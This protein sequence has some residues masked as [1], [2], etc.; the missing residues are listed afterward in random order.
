MPTDSPPGA[1]RLWEF[2]RVR[3]GPDNRRYAVANICEFT[4]RVYGPVWELD[5]FFTAVEQSAPVAMPG[6][7]VL[8]LYPES[9]EW[10]VL[11]PWYYADGQQIKDGRPARKVA[12][13][14]LLEGESRW[15]PPTWLIE[16]SSAQFPSLAFDLR[17]TTEHELYQHFTAKDGQVNQREEQLVNLQTDEILRWIQD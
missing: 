10:C 8:E 4:L 2:R 12:D 1:W 16:A 9:E 17:C 7:F 13:S 6:H 3:Q 14:V 5:Q 15:T 11:M